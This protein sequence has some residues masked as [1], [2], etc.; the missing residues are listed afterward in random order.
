M[1]R[2]E[3]LKDRRET[4]V[5][6]KVRGSRETTLPADLQAQD[7]MN[8]PN[9]KPL[10]SYLPFPLEMEDCACGICSSK[11]AS[12]LL[13][14]DSF[15]FPTRTVECQGCG[16]IYVNPRP[17][18]A[19]MEDFYTKWFRFF[20]EGR[21]KITEQYVAD[22]KWRE[23]DGSRVRRYD[24]YLSGPRRVLDVGCGAGYF[25]AQI[26]TE[27]PG[28]TVVGIEPDSMMARHCR[29]KLGLEV[30][31]GFFETFTARD[32]FDVITAF[33]VI[34]HVFDL[35][36]FLEFIW[37]RL[38]PGGI[39]VVETPDVTGAWDRTGMF[40][41]AHLYTFSPRTIRLLFELNGFE[42]LDV[43]R[44]ENELDKSNLYLIARKTSK[45]ASVPLVRDLEESARIAAKCNRLGRVRAIRILRNWAKMVYF[46]LR[47]Q[48]F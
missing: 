43:G 27:N 15:G 35:K 40:H 18:R 21:R 6:R 39:T 32:R 26:Q 16:L 46:G 5:D 34:E 17:T 31:Q 22:K 42:T 29:E 12:I 24:A 10:R 13:T 7:A 47:F 23:W 3:A 19:F 11:D 30:H 36:K 20:Y 41:I 8:S 28:S 25:A 1:A 4:P 44:L 14:F 38:R 33:H 45:A 48:L 2:G 9:G 37:D